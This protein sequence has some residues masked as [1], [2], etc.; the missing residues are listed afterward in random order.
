MSGLAARQ[1]TSIVGSIRNVAVAAMTKNLADE[2]GPS[3][4]N[5]TVVHPGLTRTERTPATVAEFAR[6]RGIDESAAEQA[7]AADVTIGRM[8][9]AAEIGD[10][11]AFLA[12]P[13]SVSINGDAVAVG[14]GAKGAIHY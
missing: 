11:I 5:V 8:V 10:V 1:A 7:L 6:A 13:R 4:V 14:G 2:L 9:T 3:G 12:S